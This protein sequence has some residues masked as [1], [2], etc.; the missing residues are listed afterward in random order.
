MPANL[1]ERAVDV[2]N[3]LI[4]SENELRQPVRLETQ[5]LKQLTMDAEVGQSMLQLLQA[6]RHAPRLF[7][8][9]SCSRA[10]ILVL[11]CSCITGPGYICDTMQQN[12]LYDYM[13]IQSMC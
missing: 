10:L 11:G 1:A 13:M 12:Q 9:H 6:R 7:D 2:Y 5:L 8:Q 3:I 4:E